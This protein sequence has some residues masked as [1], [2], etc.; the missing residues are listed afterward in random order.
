MGAI[1]LTYSECQCQIWLWALVTQLGHF[2][3]RWRH[4][5]CDGVSNHQ[6]HDCCLLKR[7][8]GHKS[9]KRSKLRITGLCAGNSSGPVNSPHKWPV[10]RKVFPFDDVIMGF[11]IELLSK[12]D[13]CTCL[14]VMILHEVWIARYDAIL[15]SRTYGKYSKHEMNCWLFLSLLADFVF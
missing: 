15:S 3:L 11:S 5:R 8:F 9:K 7:L 13:T 6:P 2:A 10:T 4:N 14:L 1:A 12:K